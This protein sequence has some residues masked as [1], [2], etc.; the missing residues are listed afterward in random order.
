MAIGVGDIFEKIK[1][2]ITVVD[3]VRVNTEVWKDLTGL[4]GSTGYDFSDLY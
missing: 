1:E 2:L 4:T 3:K